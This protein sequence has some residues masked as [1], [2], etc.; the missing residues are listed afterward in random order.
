MPTVTPAHRDRY[1]D[2]RAWLTLPFVI[3]LVI[4]GQLWYAAIRQLADERWGAGPDGKL[5][6]AQLLLLAGVL[7]LF[8]G[9]ALKLFHVPLSV[10]Y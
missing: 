10:T 1:V 9:V 8:F 6:T 4:V 2:R 7:T 5:T 3:A